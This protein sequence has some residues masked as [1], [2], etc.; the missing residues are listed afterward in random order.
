MKSKKFHIKSL[1]HLLHSF[2][3]KI[4]NWRCTELSHFIIFL[5]RWKKWQHMK[6]KFILD[7]ANENIE[8]ILH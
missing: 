1:L 3:M 6:K 7:T 2:L 5:R 8:R 4:Q